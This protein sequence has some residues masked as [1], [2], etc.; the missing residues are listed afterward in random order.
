MRFLILA[1]DH[2]WQYV[3]YR[4]ET[5]EIAAAKTRLKTVL[6]QEIADPRESLTLAASRSPR[7]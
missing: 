4:L 7:E 6:T 3:L 5:P 2:G 1:I